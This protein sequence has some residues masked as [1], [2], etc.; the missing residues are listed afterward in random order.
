LEPAKCN[1]H[2]IISLQNVKRKYPDL[3]QDIQNGILLCAFCHKFSPESPHQSAL[4]WI[5]WLQENKPEQYEYLKNYL[6]D[7]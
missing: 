6:G 7:Y 5:L 1:V 2:H 4:E 3:L